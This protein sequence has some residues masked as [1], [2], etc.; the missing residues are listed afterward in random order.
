MILIPGFAIWADGSPFHVGGD[1]GGGREEFVLHALRQ[2]VPTST[3]KER[4]ATPLS[5]GFRSLA[6]RGG[7]SDSQPTGER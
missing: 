2:S 4:A 3:G 5:L 6:E 7:E 1:W